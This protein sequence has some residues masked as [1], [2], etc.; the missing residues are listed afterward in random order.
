[1]MHNKCKKAHKKTNAPLKSWNNLLETFTV[2]TTM[3]I[4]SANG[5]LCG[6]KKNSTGKI[7]VKYSCFTVSH[8]YT[9]ISYAYF[10]HFSCAL[11]REMVTY[12]TGHKYSLCNVTVQLSTASLRPCLGLISI[13]HYWS[14]W[15]SFINF[16]ST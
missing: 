14:L 8:L 4:Y 10:V 15:F 3:I 2:N 9:P 5:Q 1:M 12:S 6:K 7:H 11:Y 16:P 13:Q